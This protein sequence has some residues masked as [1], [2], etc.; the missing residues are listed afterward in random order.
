M[1]I[2]QILVLMRNF[3]WIKVH[4]N[5]FYRYLQN[6]LAQKSITN[7]TTLNENLFRTILEVHHHG[8]KNWFY[9]NHDISHLTLYPL[10]VK[11]RNNNCSEIK[12][13][14]VYQKMGPKSITLQLVHLS[15]NIGNQEWIFGTIFDKEIV[16]LFHNNHW[17][18]FITHL[19]TLVNVKVHDP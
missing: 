2:S 15:G 10:C 13:P 7:S 3:H 16:L 12:V 18:F 17:F 5:I 19:D 9:S 11:T 1:I 6:R 14:F 8:I 4:Q